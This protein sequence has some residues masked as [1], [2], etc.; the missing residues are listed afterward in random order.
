MM[1]ADVNIKFSVE[2]EAYRKVKAKG[3]AA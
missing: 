3:D 1:L 2:L